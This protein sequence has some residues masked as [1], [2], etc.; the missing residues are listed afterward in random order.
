MGKYSEALESSNRSLAINSTYVQG[1][2][3][4]GEILYMLGY[5]YENKYNDQKNADILYNEQLS[6]FEKATTLDPDSAVAWF[7]KGFA[8]GGMNRYDEAIAAFDKV[9][10]LDPTYPHLD[11]YRNLAETNRDASTPFYVKNAFTIAVIVLCIIGAIVWY[12]AVK[13]EY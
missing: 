13:K 5:E 6:A 10:S 8:L 1:W 4:R 11:Y 2:I 3:N 9:S 12:I 7:N